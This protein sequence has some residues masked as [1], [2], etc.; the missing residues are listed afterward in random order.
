MIRNF[1]QSAIQRHIEILPCNGRPNI[2]SHRD[3]RNIFGT[4]KSDEKLTRT[5]LRSLCAPNA[6]LKTIGVMV[7]KKTADSDT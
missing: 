4:V 5:K 6:S 1:I 7:S 3:K 2:L